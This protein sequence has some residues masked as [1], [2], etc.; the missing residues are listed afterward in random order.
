MPL[1]QERGDVA[2]VLRGRARAA[3]ARTIATTSS[4]S[5]RFA[6]IVT[7]L[8]ESGHAVHVHQPEPFVTAPDRLDLRRHASYWHAVKGAALSDK[9]AAPGF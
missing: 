6:D 2:E 8:R 1:T 9:G 5:P 3:G 4:P 7:A